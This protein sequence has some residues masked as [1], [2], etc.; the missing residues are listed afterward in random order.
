MT[1]GMRGMLLGITSGMRGMILLIT[2]LLFRAFMGVSGLI[3]AIM[4]P[5]IEDCL[6]WASKK[7]L[8][9]MFS[10]MMTKHFPGVLR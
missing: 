9:I 2:G 4:S 7:S 3:S 8:S 1:R 10:I 6:I 5:T